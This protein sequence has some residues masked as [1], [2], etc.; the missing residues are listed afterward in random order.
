MERVGSRSSSGGKSVATTETLWLAKIATVPS[1]PT[2]KP[3]ALRP[4]LPSSA[5]NTVAFMTF[6]K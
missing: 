2:A 4:S 6:I 5:A 1:W 3:T